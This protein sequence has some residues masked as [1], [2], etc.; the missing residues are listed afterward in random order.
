MT[1][2]KLITTEKFGTIPC[3]FYRNMNDDILLTRE[4]IGQ[5][6]EYV[7]PRVAISKI[8]KKHKDRLDE[9]SVVTKLAATDGKSYDTTLYTQRGIMEIC[10]WSRQPKA[11]QFMDWAWDI[12]ENYRNNQ[13]NYLLNA[14][15][16]AQIIRNS[17]TLALQPL[18]DRLNTL[19]EQNAQNKLPQ[20]KYSAWKTNTFDKL[21][22]LLSYVNSHTDDNYKLSEI[23][24]LTIKETEE[25]YDLE[26]NDYIEIYRLEH[27][28]IKPFVIDAIHHYKDIRKM[29]TLTLDSILEK[30]HI[31][32]PT[33]KT[34]NIFDTL[35]A[36]NTM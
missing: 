6:L 5:A 33:Q 4:Q 14:D 29:Y 25:T 21:K 27:N 24:S 3:N 15:L 2:L 18:Y 13:Q 22:A 7:D 35:A 10:R 19:E 26:M 11:N 1:N 34:Q 8:H 32:S 17:I 16:L 31:E 36:Q 9:L 23:I 12:I 30:L 20:K 28:E